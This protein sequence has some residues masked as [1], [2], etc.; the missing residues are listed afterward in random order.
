MLVSFKADF[1]QTKRHYSFVKKK[2]IAPR[3]QTCSGEVAVKVNA[4]DQQFFA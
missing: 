4:L 1:K 3:Q 2:K